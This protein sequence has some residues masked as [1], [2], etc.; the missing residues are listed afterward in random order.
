M[1]ALRHTSYTETSIVAMMLLAWPS[2]IV[3]E[4][5]R[6][7]GY[8]GM[9]GLVYQFHGVDTDCYESLKSTED[10]RRRKKVWERVRG[11][12]TRGSTFIRSGCTI[13]TSRDP[14]VY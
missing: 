4:E 5:V 10:A 3:F 9:R 13:G 2:Q 1:M 6:C 11:L 8:G 14:R 12:C 7:T